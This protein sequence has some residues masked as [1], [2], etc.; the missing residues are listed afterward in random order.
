MI[1]AISLVW[2]TDV[3]LQCCFYHLTQATFRKIQ[4]LGLKPSYNTNA[5]L[6][7]YCEMIDGLAFLP[8]SDVKGGF[9]YL[10]SIIPNIPGVDDLLHYFDTTYINGRNTYNSIGNIDESR[11]VPPLYSPKLWNVHEATI[12]DLDRTNNF[13]ESW[14]V[15]FKTLIGQNHPTIWKAIEALRKDEILASTEIERYHRGERIQKRIRLAS[16]QHQ[17]RLHDLCVDYVSERRT[18]ADFL[19]CLGHCIRP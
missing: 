10:Q 9:I 17:K 12:N 3:K 19:N 1:N 14:N 8:L 4:S 7:H 16:R 2:G 15:K 5:E 18:L 11:H 6:K 13:C